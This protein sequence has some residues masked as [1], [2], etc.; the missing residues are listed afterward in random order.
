MFSN[1]DGISLRKK[2]ERKKNLYFFL[3]SGLNLVRPSEIYSVIKSHR[4]SKCCITEAKRASSSPL[5]LTTAHYPLI[6]SVETLWRGKMAQL[7]MPDFSL[8]IKQQKALKINHDSALGM[9]GEKGENEGNII[10]S[11]NFIC[12]CFT[13]NLPWRKKNSAKKYMAKPIE[14]HAMGAHDIFTDSCK[15]YFY[16]YHHE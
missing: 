11:V 10:K 2:K 14:R 3:P 7:Q 1:I 6:C 15:R 16:F 9:Q 5:P 12:V 13:S 8:V 4:L